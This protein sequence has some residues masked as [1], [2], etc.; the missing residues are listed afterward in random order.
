MTRSKLNPPA[1]Q[2]NMLVQNQDAVHRHQAT[3]CWINKDD[4]ASSSDASVYVRER[5]KWVSKKE[6]SPAPQDAG[7]SERWRQRY[8]LQLITIVHLNRLGGSFIF[9]TPARRPEVLRR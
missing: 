4:Q 6:P 5:M 7:C 2:H 3:G 1:V 8:R 9:H